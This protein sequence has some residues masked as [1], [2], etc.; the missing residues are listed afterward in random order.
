MGGPPARGLGVGLTTPH[1]WQKENGCNIWYM[2]CKKSVW[3]GSLMTLAK[4]I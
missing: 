3:A 2:E 1:C 4:E